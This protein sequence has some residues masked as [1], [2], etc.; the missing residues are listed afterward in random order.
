GVLSPGVYQDGQKVAIDA[1]NVRSGERRRLAWRIESMES[2]GIHTREWRFDPSTLHWG[3]TVF[4]TALPCDFLVVDEIGPLELEYG[5]GW[6]AALSAIASRAYR[7]GVI[8]LR[9]SLLALAARWSPA[10]VLAVRRPDQP[11][12]LAELLGED[13]PGVR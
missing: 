8:V 6:I 12:S 5:Q 4:E 1:V 7:L 13:P 11:L 2:G 3:N 10:Y 9:P